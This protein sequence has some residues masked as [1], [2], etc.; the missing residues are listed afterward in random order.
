MFESAESAHL[1]YDWIIVTY[2]FLGGVSV[3]A[4]LFSL[5]ASYWKQEFKHLALKGALLSLISLGLG[6]LILFVD[7]GRHDRAFLLVTRFNPHSMVSWG[8]WFLNI[9]GLTNLI[10]TS[11]LFKD[12]AEVAKK[13]AYLGLPFAVLTATYT[14]M[15]LAQAPGRILWHTALLPVLFLNGVMAKPQTQQQRN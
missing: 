11:L 14:A 2:F 1:A 7:L 9:Y 5:A 3:G 12:K 15:L 6:M 8:V 4:Y 10:Y 13:F